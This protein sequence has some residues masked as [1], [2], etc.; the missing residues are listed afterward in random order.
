MPETETVT[1]PNG[2]T[3]RISDVRTLQKSFTT[4]DLGKIECPDEACKCSW[5]YCTKHG[6]YQCPPPCK[7]GSHP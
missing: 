6:A 5:C 4:G 7:M 3:S 2:H 1:C